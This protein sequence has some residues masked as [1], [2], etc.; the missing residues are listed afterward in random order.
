[1]KAVTIVTRFMK[2]SII[3]FGVLKSEDIWGS[4]IFDQISVTDIRTRL[5]I[6]L[7]YSTKRVAAYQTSKRKKSFN[8]FLLWIYSLNHSHQKKRSPIIIPSQNSRFME[9]P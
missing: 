4:H 9:T 5:F 3:G 6:T 8:N 7:K 1:M 2:V